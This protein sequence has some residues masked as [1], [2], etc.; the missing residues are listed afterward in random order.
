MMAAAVAT[1]L[2][3]DPLSEM[4]GFNHFQYSRCQIISDPILP[5]RTTTP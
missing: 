4:A 5:L 2:P 1:N 3:F